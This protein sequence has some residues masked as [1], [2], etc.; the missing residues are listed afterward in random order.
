MHWRPLRDDLFNFVKPAFWNECDAHC[1]SPSSPPVWNSKRDSLT[2]CLF[3]HMI[4]GK[5]MSAFSVNGCSTC[6]HVY[7]NSLCNFCKAFSAWSHHVNP[8]YQSCVFSHPVHSETRQHDK[9]DRTLRTASFAKYDKG[10]NDEQIA[11]ND[12]INL[13]VDILYRNRQ[14]L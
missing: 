11:A 5:M 3:C 4:R 13:F 7:Y 2:V 9:R 10:E 14:N 12:W 1:Q 6:L 8:E